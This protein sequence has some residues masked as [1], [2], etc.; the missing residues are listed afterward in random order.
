VVSKL[1]RFTDMYLSTLRDYVEAVGGRLEIIA[2]FHDQTVR[3]NHFE[4]LDS[5]SRVRDQWS[6][7]R[8]TG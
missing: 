4:A 6:V 3:I 1:E 8:A 2:R 5:E 7:R